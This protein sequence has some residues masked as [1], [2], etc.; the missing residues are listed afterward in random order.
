MTLDFR[1]IILFCFYLIAKSLFFI[2]NTSESPADKTLNVISFKYEI[3]SDLELNVENEQTT[4]KKYRNICKRNNKSICTHHYYYF[5]PLKCY[6]VAFA[7][8][9]ITTHNI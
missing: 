3:H 6:Y 1:Q 2:Y 7:Q 4:T 5:I 8:L 9:L